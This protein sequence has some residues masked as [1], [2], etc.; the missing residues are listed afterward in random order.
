MSI[1]LLTIIEIVKCLGS[2]K[3]DSSGCSNSDLNHI[4]TFVSIESLVSHVDFSNFDFSIGMHWATLLDL[5][6]ARERRFSPR[7][8]TR[9]RRG[10]R[11]AAART[12]ILV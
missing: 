3:I 8:F 12:R 9:E 11:N 2:I 1:C 6:A 10:P 7:P 5:G 4:A